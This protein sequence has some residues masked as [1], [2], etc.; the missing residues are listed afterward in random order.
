MDKVVGAMWRVPFL[1]SRFPL[2]S[3]VGCSALSLGEGARVRAGEP[4]LGWLAREIHE[5]LAVDQRTGAA[6]ALV[7]DVKPAK[8]E[9]T[10]S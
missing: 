2:G 9:T 5:D 3:R 7:C 6:T 1:P 10:L 4:R 8:D